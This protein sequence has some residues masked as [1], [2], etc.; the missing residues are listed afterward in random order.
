MNSVYYCG[1]HNYIG[2]VECPDCLVVAGSTMPTSAHSHKCNIHI[3][4]PCN[5]GAESTPATGSA[6]IPTM[7]PPPDAKEEALRKKILKPFLGEARCR[8]GAPE[9]MTFG[10]ELKL[11]FF[12]PDNERTKQSLRQLKRWV[13]TNFRE[14][15]TCHHTRQPAELAYKAPYCDGG[16]GKNVVGFFHCSHCW[17]PWK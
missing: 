4:A 11:P 3:G 5:C 9:S 17:G 10:Q 2:T 6:T 8:L 7:R 16:D 15:P 14:W 13:S 1:G 12:G